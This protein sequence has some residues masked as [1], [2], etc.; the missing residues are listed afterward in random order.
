MADHRKRRTEL[1][2]KAKKTKISI[3]RMAAKLLGSQFYRVMATT[4]RYSIHRCQQVIL[5]DVDF[6]SPI[7]RIPRRPSGHYLQQV[8]QTAIDRAGHLQAHATTSRSALSISRP[9]YGILTDAAKSFVMA[10]LYISRP[11]PVTDLEKWVR[12]DGR[13]YEGELKITV[14]LII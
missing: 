7:L 1:L 13:R 8:V 9:R 11:L 4:Q 6:L 14:D 5:Q 10:L 2:G 12:P 3:S